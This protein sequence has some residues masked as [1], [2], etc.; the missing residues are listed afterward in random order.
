VLETYKSSD[1]IVDYSGLTVTQQSTDPSVMEVKFRYRPA[2][3][4][5][6]VL[7]SFGIDQTTGT[8]TDVA[9]DVVAA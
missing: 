7:I 3:P 9:T 4:L 2:Y 5:N 1:V 8:V 6:Y